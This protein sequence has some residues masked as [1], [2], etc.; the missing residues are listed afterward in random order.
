MT[1]IDKRAL[2][3]I[4]QALS[5]KGYQVIGPK[6]ES[7]AIVLATIGSM[8]EL[9]VGIKDEQSAGRY[10]LLE[11]EK[12]TIFGFSNG[13]HSLKLF[14][15]PPKQRLYKTKRKSKGLEI[16]NPEETQKIAFIGVRACDI[17]ALKALDRV[18]KD[19]NNYKKRRDNIFI[20]A[21]NCTSHS[22]VCFCS[23]VN[24]GPEVKDNYDLLLTEMDNDFFLEVATEKGQEIIKGITQKEPDDNEIRKKD[25]LL[26]KTKEGMKKTLNTEGLPE[27]LYERVNSPLWEEIAKKDLSCGNCTMVCPTCFCNTSFDI[28][29]FEGENTERQRLWDSCFSLGF[30]RVHGGSFRASRQARY[31]QW[32]MHKLAYWIEQYGMPGCVGCGRCITWCPASID[33]TESYKELIN[34]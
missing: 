3:E 22:D 17:C 15:N 19:D 13:A 7:D 31:R 27:S 14:L 29:D 1:L 5:E 4:I 25:E 30:A 23:S 32:L 10:R 16:S 20:L 12:N 6:I 34:G 9:P 18:F 26:R 8:D 33:I 21:V 28:S 2:N 24:T 11:G